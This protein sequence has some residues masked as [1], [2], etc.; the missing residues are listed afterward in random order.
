MTQ[1]ALGRHLEATAAAPP[2]RQIDCWLLLLARPAE[3]GQTRRRR[4]LLRA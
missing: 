4:T 3:P 2:S 1:R